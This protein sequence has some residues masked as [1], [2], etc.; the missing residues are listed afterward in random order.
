MK[1]NLKSFF[2]WKETAKAKTNSL[3]GLK[4]LVRFIIYVFIKDLDKHKL[5]NGLILGSNA[6]KGNS[7]LI[8][9]FQL[10]SFNKI[11]TQ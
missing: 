9:P 7:K 6:V 5:K 1:I 11:Q 4:L 10:P 2:K 8:I 3:N